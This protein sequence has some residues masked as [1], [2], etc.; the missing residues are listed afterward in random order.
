[1]EVAN[2]LRD[3]GGKNRCNKLFCGRGQRVRW[4]GCNYNTSRRFII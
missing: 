3:C 1:M 2:L 4:T